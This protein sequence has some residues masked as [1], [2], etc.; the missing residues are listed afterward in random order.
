MTITLDVMNALR[1]LGAQ[2]VCRGACETEADYAA[3]VDIN[4]DRPSWAALC[5]LMDDMRRVTAADVRAEASQRMQALFGARDAGHLQIVLSNAS[6]EAIRLLRIK[7]VRAWTPEEAARAAQLE[8]A[9]ATIEAIRAASNVMEASPP[10]SMAA[11][12]AAFDAVTPAQP[13]PLPP[14]RLDAIETQV[15]GILASIAKANAG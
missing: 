4:G 15:A 11:V 14:E 8:A 6:R 2:A 13:P 9:D 5:A 3:N 12:T 7:A 10:H 1:V